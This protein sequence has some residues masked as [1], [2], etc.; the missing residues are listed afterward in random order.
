[1][2]TILIEYPDSLAAVANLSGDE[3]AREA[4][5]AMAVKL[6][7]IGRLS[8]GQAAQLAECSRIEFLFS[9]KRFGAATVD[10]D[11][12]ELEREQRALAEMAQ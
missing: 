3:F 6:Y 11:K 9:C 12:E 2:G 8:S 1:M 4:R 10:W 7:E 5:L